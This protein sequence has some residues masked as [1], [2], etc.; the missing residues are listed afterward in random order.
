[1]RIL[2]AMV[3]VI[4]L[5]A[6]AWL[7][8]AADER[9]AGAGQRSVPARAARREDRAP[10]RPPADDAPAPAS[11]D[12]VDVEQASP[13]V[14]A[15]VERIVYGTIVNERGEPATNARTVAS[16]WDRTRLPALEFRQ[17][18]AGAGCYALA[19]LAPGD[20]R[21]RSRRRATGPASAR[22]CSRRPR[23]P[24]ASTSPCIAIRAW[25]CSSPPKLAHR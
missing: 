11:A 22:A 20:G 19:G 16:H 18:F 24:A 14:T 8:L 5:I 6:A 10:E 9:D 17:A 1:M 7:W 21:S 2:L 4:G 25:R 3:I 15:D 13:G 12:R 23:R